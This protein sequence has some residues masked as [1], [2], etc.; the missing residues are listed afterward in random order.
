MKTLIFQDLLAPVGRRLGSMIAGGLLTLGAAQGV[1]DQVETL[2]PA[3]VALAC[4]LVFSH[5]SRS[6]RGAN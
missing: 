3:L 1:A 4:D 2:V 6:R 5:Y